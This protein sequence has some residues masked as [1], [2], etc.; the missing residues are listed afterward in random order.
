MVLRQGMRLTLFGL[1]LGLA[2]AFG[3]TRLMSS[4]LYQVS[5]NDVPTYTG[6]SVLLLLVAG[7]AC[8]LPARRAFTIE[9]T[10]ALRNE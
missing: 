3:V 4:V 1:V 5:P 6:I 8:Y 10:Q 7:L 2:G 9:P